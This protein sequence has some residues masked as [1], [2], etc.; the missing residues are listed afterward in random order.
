MS[1]ADFWRRLRRPVR[2]FV[3]PEPAH[4]ADPFS[5]AKVLAERARRSVVQQPAEP[6]SPGI[7]ADR[8]SLFATIREIGSTGRRR[9]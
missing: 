7:H 9:S 5:Q 2:G 4:A 8:E 3:S 6:D 1:D